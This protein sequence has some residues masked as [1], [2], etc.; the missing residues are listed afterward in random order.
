MRVFILRVL[1]R[2]APLACAA[3]AWTC[4]GTV[5]EQVTPSSVAAVVV[6]PSAMTLV[7]GQQ[8]PMQASVRDAAGNTVS[9][10][11]VVWSVRDNNIVSVSTAGIVTALAIGTTEVAANSSGKSGVA[12]ITVQRVPVATV[13]VL[14]RQVDAIVGSRTTLTAVAYDAGG[15]TLTGRSFIWSSSNT[16]VATVD[17]SGVVTA[18]GPGSATVTATAEGKSDA[19]TVAVTLTPVATVTLAPAVLSMTVG[20]MTQLTATARDANGTVL[21][22]RPVQW[23]SSNTAVALVAA[24]G[25][26]SALTD[27]SANITATIGGQSAIAAVTVSGVPVATVTIQPQTAS[28]NENASQQLTATTRD[29]GANILMR[30]VTWTTSNSTIAVVTQAGLVTARAAGTATITATSEGIA[31]TATVTVLRAPVASVVVQPSAAT[32]LVGR[33]T[34]FTATVMDALNTPLAGRVVTWTSSNTSVATVS[35]TGEVTGVASGTATITATSEGIPGRATVTVSAVA[36]GTVTVAPATVNVI[37]GQTATL[38]ATVR[39]V[40]GAVVTDRA[41]TW[42]S[43]APAVAGVSTTGVVTG[44]GA[45]TATITAT[46]EGRSGTA[47]VTV[48][49][50]P[51]HTVTVEPPN[52]TLTVGNRITLTAVTRDEAGNVLTGRVVTWSLGDESI[53][54]VTST[55]V[56]TGVGPGT[57]TITATSEGKSG[58]SIVTVQPT[59]VASVTVQPATATVAIGATTTLTAF[60]RDS[61]GNVLNGRVVSWISSNTAIATVNG[62]GVVTGVA[63]GSVTITATSEGRSGTATVTVP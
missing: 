1:R 56:V 15:N 27:G 25:T 41:V 45:G 6:N 63:R 11:A 36:V 53:V 18:N 12:V 14:P 19:A 35:S 48:T 51:V 38:V 58:T 20:Q 34:T 26:V 30:P 28:I 62:S 29:A 39:D 17:A 46:S 57:S 4:S 5:S 37:V 40:N 52:V 3:A 7:V 9:G 16:V 22:G 42:S 49:T 2:G 54:G 47:T 13:A 33:T 31:G 44:V 24:D 23:S 32:V 10:A 61:S 55:G 21:V 43:S 59:P 8:Q 60:V 50:I